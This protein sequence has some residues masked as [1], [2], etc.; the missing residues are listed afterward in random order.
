MK[1][2]LPSFLFIVL[3]ASAPLLAQ[4]KNRLEATNYFTIYTLQG[5][6][7]E[8]AELLSEP[9]FQITQRVEPITNCELRTTNWDNLDEDL[10]CHLMMYSESSITGSISRTAEEGSGKNEQPVHWWNSLITLFVDR[11]SEEGVPSVRVDEDIIHTKTAKEKVTDADSE[12][13]GSLLMNGQVNKYL[14]NEIISN[15][16]TECLAEVAKLTFT[17]SENVSKATA[18]WAAAKAAAEYFKKTA[19][20]VKEAATRELKEAKDLVD[21]MEISVGG[22]YIRRVLGQVRRLFSDESEQQIYE[23]YIIAD[24]EAKKCAYNLADARVQTANAVLFAISVHNTGQ[25]VIAHQELNAAQE[26][27]R[28]ALQET[29][30]AKATAI[31]RKVLFRQANINQSDIKT[32]ITLRNKLAEQYQKNEKY[33]AAAYARWSA[34]M[35]DKAEKANTWQLT[36]QYQLAAEYDRKAAEA[37]ESGD[38]EKFTCFDQVSTTAWWSACQLELASAVLKKASSTSV[39]QNHSH[40][41]RVAEQYKVAAEYYRKSAEACELGDKEKFTRFSQCGDLVTTSISIQLESTDSLSDEKLTNQCKVAAEYYL[42]A[43][44]KL[45]LGNEQEFTRF[46][47]AA[48][49]ARC[50]VLWLKQASTV[51]E[52]AI[53]EHWRKSAEA[54]AQGNKTQ[55]DKAVKKALDIMKNNKLKKNDCL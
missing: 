20:R 15:I 23:A 44:E 9:S 52:K 21:E 55:G 38:K 4:D 34:Y 12:F 29:E 35:L 27:E 36:D 32:N 41:V 45:A 43:A 1:K 18:E 31:N 8:T 28:N 17:S 54:Y 7:P 48:S 47:E 49:A 51:E 50:S 10:S 14:K 46:N 40:F 19:E 30:T 3:A 16:Y 5:T 37:S 33:E 42:I 53:S 6:G 22:V 25:E 24:Y 26:V 11:G 2:I 39:P 13:E